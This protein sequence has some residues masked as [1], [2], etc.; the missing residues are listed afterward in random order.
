LL[1]VFLEI[2]HLE[3]Y[4]AELNEG[5]YHCGEGAVVRLLAKKV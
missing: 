3:E 4:V 5:K 2:Q 1:K